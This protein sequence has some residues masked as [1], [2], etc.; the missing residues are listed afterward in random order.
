MNMRRA[1]A[2]DKVVGKT[3]ALLFIANGVDG[4]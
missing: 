4:I 1:S 2:A 3:V